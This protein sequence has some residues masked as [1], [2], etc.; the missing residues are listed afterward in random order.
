MAKY[1]DDD[2]WRYRGIKRRDFRNGGVDEEDFDLYF[3]YQRRTSSKVPRGQCAKD[4]GNKCAEFYWKPRWSTRPDENGY[5]KTYGSFF[6]KRCHRLDW[7][8]WSHY[9]REY[10]WSADQRRQTS[11]VV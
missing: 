9:I 1:K 10:N 3:Y 6:C 8:R 11:H 5:Y 2:S 4:P 7:T